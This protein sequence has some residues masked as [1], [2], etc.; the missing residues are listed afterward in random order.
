MAGTFGSDH[1]HIDRRRGDD[2]AEMDIESMPER[3][4]RTRLQVRRNLLPI[5]GSLCLVR[6]QDHDNIGRFHRIRYGHDL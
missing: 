4:V 5:E 3:K 6:R 1:K 2:L